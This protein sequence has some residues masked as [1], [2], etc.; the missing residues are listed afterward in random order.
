AAAVALRERTGVQA[1][2]RTA[3]SAHHHRRDAPEPGPAHA[4]RRM[5]AGP[6]R[7]PQR[8]AGRG[9][10]TTG[11]SLMYA[12]SHMDMNSFGRLGNFD[13]DRPLDELIDRL[14]DGE[15]T[16]DEWEAFR[17][18]AATCHEPWRRLAEEQRRMA[19]LAAEVEAV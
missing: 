4:S 16:E 3:R 2:R 18:Q 14:V 12:F 1:D 8:R 11:E 19:R 15:A 10:G 6:G 7:G 13:M 9:R 17:R 5:D